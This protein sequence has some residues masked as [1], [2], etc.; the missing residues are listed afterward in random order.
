MTDETKPPEEQRT[1]IQLG[2][3]WSPLFDE[4]V[5]LT[6]AENRGDVMKNALSLYVHL[7][8]CLPGS[9]DL[10]A[11]VQKRLNHDFKV[12]KS[13]PIHEFGL[14]KQAQPRAHKPD[15]DSPF[16]IRTL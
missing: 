15:E 13:V 10:L 9:P 4:M 7:A 3:A 11:I 5:E 6:T 14:V 16:A 12:L 8:K 2:E 1:C